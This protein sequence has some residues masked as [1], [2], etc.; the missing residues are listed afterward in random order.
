MK[1]FAIAIHGGAGAIPRSVMGAENEKNYKKGLEEALLAGDTILSSGGNALD[2]VEAAVNKLEDNPLFN[3]G[4]GAVFTNGGT[5]ELDAS[6]MDGKNLMAGAVTGIKN[7]KNPVSLARVVMEKSEHV[8]LSGAGAMEFAKKMNQEFAPD[9][10][11]FVQDRYDQLLQAR[12]SDQVVL[13]HGNTRGTTGT[14]N[15]KKGTVGAVAL[16]I[17]GNIAAATSTGG[18]TNKKFGRV[19]D[20]PIIGAGTYANNN[21][22]AISCTGHGEFFI[23]SV[24]AYDIS[25]LMEY[26]GLSLKEACDIVVYQKLVNIGGEG[27]LVAIDAKGN[28]EMPFNSE[29]MYRAMRKSGGEIYLGIYKDPAHS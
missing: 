25:C 23:R 1:Q 18:M 2:A 5:N 8:F 15:S 7:V 16:D 13:D 24:V 19:G 17:F 20:S 14:P 3:A 4:R 12:E 22:C 26:K 29:G 9:E 10:Y 28:I 11:F 27:G 6:I 21:T